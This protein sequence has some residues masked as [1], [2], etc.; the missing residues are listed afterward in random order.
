MRRMTKITI[1]GHRVMLEQERAAL[2]VVAARA[3]IDDTRLDQLGGCAAAMGIMA[4][5]AGQLPLIDGMMRGIIE[6][7]P[8]I[9]MAAVAH[10][11]LCIGLQ[12]LVLVGVYVVTRY[13]CDICIAVGA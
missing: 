6:L 11:R 12:H 8:H 1:L 5:G 2:I 7:R 10:G 13:T 9:L 4:T 3:R